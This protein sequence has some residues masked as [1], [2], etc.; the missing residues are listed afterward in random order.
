MTFL[1]PSSKAKS[2]KNIWTPPWDILL[3]ARG[4]QKGFFLHLKGF[5]RL[6]KALIGDL[7]RALQQG[8]KPKEYQ[9]PPMGYSFG[10]AKSQKNIWT[11]PWVILLE[12]RGSQK[13]FF[14]HLKGLTRLRKA[15]IG[16]LPRAFQQSKK[17]K[18]YLDLLASGITLHGGPVRPSQNRVKG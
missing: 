4:S 8:K 18:E 5:K 11:L 13:G 14:L 7:P 9:D 2:Q 12:T 1:G 15:L 6:E 3:E 17:P 16:D 10:K